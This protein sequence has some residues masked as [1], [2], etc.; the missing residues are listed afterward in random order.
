MISMPVDASIYQN[1]FHNASPNVAASLD[2]HPCHPQPSESASFFDLA[3]LDDYPVDDSYA[4]YLA[5]AHA[6]STIAPNDTF[7][8]IPS[9]TT[10]TPPVQTVSP[11]EIHGHSPFCF[12]QSHDGAP[13]VDITSPTLGSSS[14]IPQSIFC[15]S[16]HVQRHP[17]NPFVPSFPTSN[18]ILAATRSGYSPQ[19]PP[20]RRYSL[21]NPQR[22]VPCH[23]DPFPRR[24]SWVPPTT[25]PMH[26]QAYLQYPFLRSASFGNESESPYS[27]GS[28]SLSSVSYDSWTYR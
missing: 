11:T 23:S 27:S 8:Y 19:I 25:A 9:Q 26:V 17:S 20:E 18:G 13:V 6:E 24:V 15:S 12:C 16:A 10:I 2:A 22:P 3:R 5:V 4:A 21:P 14:S 1:P 28:M 7:L